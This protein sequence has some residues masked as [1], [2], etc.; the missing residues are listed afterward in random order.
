M[1]GNEYINRA[2]DYILNHINEELTVDNIAS[3]IGFSRFHFSRLFKKETGEGIFQFIKRIRMEQ[4][5]FRLKVETDKSIT[6]IGGDYG[7]SSSNYS[8]AFKQHHEITPAQFRQSIFQKSLTNPIYSN[9]EV[10]LESYEECC[11]KITV[12]N[13]PDQLVIYQRYKG[14][15]LDLSQHWDEFQECYKKFITE[16]TLFLERTYND[17]SITNID[18]C[19]YDICMSA[20][21]NCPLENTYT[22]K[23]GKFAVYHFNGN[24]KQLYSVYQS[25]FS[26]WFPQSKYQLDERY[27]Y[28]IYRNIDCDSM[29]MKIDLCSPIR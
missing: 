7:Y 28:E 22:I 5:A 20:P 18:E 19:L 6:E 8:T 29:I 3:Y 12:E 13:L 9:T 15:Y 11:K 24:V 16:E 10:Q 25:I 14:N 27:D 4:S 1:I 17:P 26:V 23:G 21:E 2:I